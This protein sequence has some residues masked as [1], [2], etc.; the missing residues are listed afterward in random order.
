MAFEK[1]LSILR[2]LK[3][4][5][6]KIKSCFEYTIRK[7]TTE[8]NNNVLF[9]CS[10]KIKGK[11]LV[12]LIYYF[13]SCGYNCYL[14]YSFRQCLKL[15]IH[16]ICAI[17]LREIFQI[18][19]KFNNFSVIV[20]PDKQSLDSFNSNALKIHLNYLE[21]KNGFQNINEVTENDFYYPIGFHQTFYFPSCYG[22]NLS[23]SIESETLKNVFSSN[24][25]IGAIFA[26]ALF[27][28]WDGQTNK[29]NQD[30]IK[31]NFCI[32]NR[33]TIFS[34]ILEKLPQ[35]HLYI[36]DTL[37]DFLDSMEAGHLKNKTVL[38]ERNNFSI[39]YEK[40]FEVLLNTNF[41]IHMP[42]VTYPFCHNQIE[43]MAAGCIP[44]TQL[45]KFF[46]PSFTHEFD[47]LLFNTPDELINLLSSVSTGKYTSKINDMRNE[48]ANY[49]ID[50]YSIESFRKRLSF[51]F[52]KNIKHTK[53]WIVLP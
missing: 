35:E 27:C 38:I 37:K 51:L 26:G 12:Q 31:E 50:H 28:K 48:I 9:L 15:N 10:T 1:K 32:E 47:S 52:D 16:G 42:G 29:Y 41:Y 4:K 53:F 46:I 40:Y 49:Y 30:S 19:K 6:N 25:K 36:P 44:I 22:V 2:R 45:G 18:K 13:R 3:R 39:P 21:I 5:F 17:S 7:S 34:H 43:S 20:S 33:G 24:R 14:D 8:T 23:Q 11:N